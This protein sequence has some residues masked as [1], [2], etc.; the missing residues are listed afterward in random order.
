MPVLDD[1][2]VTSDNPVDKTTV[3]IVKSSIASQLWAWAYEHQDHV[4]ISRK[5]LLWT[6]K[7]RVRDLFPLFELLLGEPK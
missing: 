6:V 1:I 7:I 2:D 4:I 5:L 3:D